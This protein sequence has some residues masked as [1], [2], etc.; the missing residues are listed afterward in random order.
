MKRFWTFWCAALCVAG[1]SCT[2]GPSADKL[3]GVWLEPIPGMDGFQ[4]M[5]LSADGTARSVNMA[6]LEYDRWQL[7]GRQLVLAGKS[8]GNGQT[9][10]FADTLD[11]VRVDA[12]SLILGRGDGRR[13]YSRAADAFDAEPENETHVVLEGTVTF[14]PEVR[15]FRAAGDS[16]TFWLIDESGCL[17]QRFVELGRA[18]WTVGAELELC[19]VDNSVAEFAADYDGAYRVVRILR[20]D[21]A[22]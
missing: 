20:L 4:G 5:A 12:D 18:E 1:T 13:A 22:E 9:L 6:T 15:T 16:T 14:A 11:I 3:V 17:E 2:S 21:E 7:L 10:G 8:I 19:P